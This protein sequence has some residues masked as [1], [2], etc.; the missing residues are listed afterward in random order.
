MWCR[1]H[2][3]V[4]VLKPEVDA[5]GYDVVFSHGRVMRHV[6]IKASLMGGA[7]AEQQISGDLAIH[8]SPCVVWAIVDNSL[9]FQHFY[10]YGAAPGEPLPEIAGLKPARQARANA[11]GVKAFRLNTWRLPRSKFTRVNT[12][13]GIAERLFGAL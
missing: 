10:W 7:S 11:Q 1:N 6:Q 13:D 5:A 9:R 12:V 4:D 8:Q 2:V 3:N